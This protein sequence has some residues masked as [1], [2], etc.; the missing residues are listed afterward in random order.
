[1]SGHEGLLVVITT[2]LFLLNSFLWGFA[3]AVIGRFLFTRSR[4]GHEPRVA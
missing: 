2:F 4:L 1:M 3:L